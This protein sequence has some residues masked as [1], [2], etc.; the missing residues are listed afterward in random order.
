MNHK[1][2]KH[3]PLTEASYYILLSLKSPIH[4]YGIIKK[5]EEMTN[6][7]L[8]LSAGT[9]YGVIMKFMKT[10]LIKLVSEQVTSKKKKEYVITQDGIDLLN[11]ELKRLKEMVSNSEIEVR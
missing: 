4:G 11:Y 7:R 9:L 2:I 10:N 3:S 1:V 5:V 8:L 6:G